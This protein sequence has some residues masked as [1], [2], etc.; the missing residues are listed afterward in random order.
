MHTGDTNWVAARYGSTQGET[1]A[2]NACAG[3][4]AG[5]EHR[6]T[7]QA[8][9]IVDWPVGERDGYVFTPANTVV[10]RVPP[11]ALG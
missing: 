7:H 6:E 10:E 8:D 4:R 9:D 2:G 1:P 3:G 5:G 11:E